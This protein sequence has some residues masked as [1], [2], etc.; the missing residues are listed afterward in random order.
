M[1]A[2]SSEGQKMS[3]SCGEVTERRRQVQIFGSNTEYLEDYIC[4][5]ACRC[6]MVLAGL[7]DGGGSPAQNST[8]TGSTASGS[9]SSEYP[10][11]VRA[12]KRKASSF[13]SRLKVTAMSGEIALPFE[14]VSQ[15]LQL[16]AM[17]RDIFISALAY[18]DRPF[19]RELLNEAT[20]SRQFTVGAVLGLLCDSDED[21][22]RMRN[23]LVPSSKLFHNGLL[24]VSNRGDW[25]SLSVGAFLGIKLEIPL[26]LCSYIT[27]PDT[28][29]I[30][31]RGSISF[32]EPRTEAAAGCGSIQIRRTA[33]YEKARTE[34][35][36]AADAARP[37]VI[38][39]HGHA[40][41]PVH[42]AVTELASLMEKRILSLHVNLNMRRAY[43]KMDDVIRA[44]SVAWI[45]DAIP[46][47]SMSSDPSREEQEEYV[48][49]L[50]SDHARRS[51][52]IIV[53]MTGTPKLT[54]EF[55]R[56]V[57][58][59][60]HIP[61]PSSEYRQNVIVDSLPK[62]TRL[63]DDVDLAKLAEMFTES[64]EELKHLAQDA[65]LRATVRTG[66][67]GI[68]RM[69]DFLPR[70]GNSVLREHTDGDI[71][72]HISQPRA[73]L[74]SLVL[75]DAL[76]TQVMHIITAAR[77][78]E[79]VLRRWGLG[80]E[81]G[82]GKGISA[83]FYG[84]TGTGKTLAAEAIAG[85]LGMPLS[86]VRIS[87]V[88]N[89]FVGQT[90]KNTVEVFREAQARNSVLV[91]DEA[92][93]LFATRASSDEHHS[94]YINSHINTLLK[95]M[96]DFCGI[97]ILTT[98]LHKNMDP[99]FERRIR[100][101]LEFSPPTQETRERLWKKLMP[102]SVPRT[103][104]VD[105]RILAREFGFTGG[106]IR[107]TVLKAAF[108]AASEGEVISMSHLRNAAL[109]ETIEE[110]GSVG[111]TAFGFSSIPSAVN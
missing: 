41:E 48:R 9:S 90:E 22:I 12:W 101:K 95:V 25:T 62:G 105:F 64:E 107:N 58:C 70:M 16:S 23:L 6:R 93:A 47:F 84:P 28:V 102:E 52:T 98:N 109:T 32:I 33:E 82:T 8:A 106:L 85:E 103:E 110:T 37:D 97:V 44:V 99:A 1:G 35:P 31:S 92:D 10:A 89:R 83:L 26:L 71:V 111:S 94:Y 29:V 67:S 78:R 24:T 38:L 96:E 77:S 42:Q 14:T 19:F 104:D 75:T 55:Q 13:R 100:W 21:R 50:R 17:E 5:L 39:I 57:T 59:M 11:A 60:L 36:V 3:R 66:D 51:G 53:T 34:S 81:Y 80:E 18:Y 72:A 4:V 54:E 56:I 91:F 69:E 49:L 20:G 27:C 74:D 76:H 7:T 88:M 108:M 30:G 65:C 2:A 40:G 87:E 61:P 15:K 45:L 68:L 73:T 63:G 43:E 79:T 86:V 46:W